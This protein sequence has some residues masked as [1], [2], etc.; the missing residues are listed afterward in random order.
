[1][2]LAAQQAVDTTATSNTLTSVLL[3]VFVVSLA[4]TAGL[5]ARDILRQS[6]PDISNDPWIQARGIETPAESSPHQTASP[7]VHRFPSDR[8]LRSESVLRQPHWYDQA[9]TT[10]R[11]HA[12]SKIT[13]IVEQLVNAGNRGDMNTALSLYSMDYR[14]R[15]EREHQVVP[16]SLGRF[17]PASAD[18]SRKATWVDSV[19]QV[20]VDPSN[21][22]HALVS[23]A[24]ADGAPVSPERYA[25]TFDHDSQDWLIDSIE[26][27]ETVE[28]FQ[29][30]RG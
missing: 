2:L 21:R 6:K 10:F 30:H 9:T 15:F 3:A 22:V 13:R 20:V 8:P 12:T 11:E 19:T 28:T 29:A 27:A 25:F 5:L 24:T 7:T 4:I 17:P 23:Y 18:D 16:E 26:S 1:M 14:A